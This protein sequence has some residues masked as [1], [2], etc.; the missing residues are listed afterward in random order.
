[1]RSVFVDGRNS[2]WHIAFGVLAVKYSIIIPIFLMY[3]F[4]LKP[5]RNSLVDTVEFAVGYVLMLLWIKIAYKKKG[6]T[7][8]LNF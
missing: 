6:W 5:D 7:V 1:M 3:Q 8:M 2:V 4:I